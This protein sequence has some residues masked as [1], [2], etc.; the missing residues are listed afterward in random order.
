[1]TVLTKIKIYRAAASEHAELSNMFF[2]IHRHVFVL[3]SY[4]FIGSST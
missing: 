1:M 3:K 2:I 4:A